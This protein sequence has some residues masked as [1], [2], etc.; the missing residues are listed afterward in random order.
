MPLGTC[1]QEPRHA[2]PCGLSLLGLPLPA[3]SL[4]PA[5]SS[6]PAQAASARVTLSSLGSLVPL[7]NKEN[8]A[9]VQEE[10]ETKSNTLEHPT[11]FLVVCG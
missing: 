6:T 9:W 8:R 3:P 7:L 5:F 4:G 10:L 11:C 1:L 2:F